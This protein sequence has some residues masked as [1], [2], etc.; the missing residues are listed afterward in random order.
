MVPRRSCN[1]GGMQLLGLPQQ[2]DHGELTLTL[3]CLHIN[4][5]IQRWHPW[6][7]SPVHWPMK[8][9]P[10]GWK[11]WTSCVSAEE[12]RI[13]YGWV[14]SLNDSDF[15]Q[16]TYLHDMKQPK[17]KWILCKYISVMDSIVSYFVIKFLFSSLLYGIF[18]IIFCG[19]LSAINCWCKAT[20]PVN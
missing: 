7:P 5:S 9:L 1:L 15:G 4:T 19:S 14:W 6:M 3:K 16:V 2:R 10:E 17:L 13:R 18:S 8:W 12:W 20:F 11:L